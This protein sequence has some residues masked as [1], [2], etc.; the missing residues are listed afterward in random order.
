MEL[1]VIA[2]SEKKFL[3][4]YDIPI[5]YNDRQIEVMR[6]K[7][8]YQKFGSLWYLKGY[9]GVIRKLSQILAIKMTYFTISMDTQKQIIGEYTINQFI[10]AFKIENKGLNHQAMK[11]IRKLTIK[12]ILK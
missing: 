5:L 10:R 12:K 2:L 1:N 6:F 3:I 4:E 7:I 11:Q 8:K 9:N